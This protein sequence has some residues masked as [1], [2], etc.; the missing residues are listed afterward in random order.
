MDAVKYFK[1]KKRMTKGCDTYAK[2]HECPLYEDN[3]IFK[4]DC[5]FFE[6]NHPEEAV[7]IV[8]KW[9]KEHHIATRMDKFINEYPKAEVKKYKTEKFINICPARINNKIKCYGIV[10]GDECYICKVKYWNEEA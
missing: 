5:T 10:H 4:E 2:C 1:E 7:A 6:I 8:E 9:A 3:N